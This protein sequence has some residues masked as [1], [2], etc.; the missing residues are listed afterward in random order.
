[1]AGILKFSNLQIGQ[2]SNC[3]WALPAARAIRSY[4]CR[5]F[6]QAGIH[7]YH[8]YVCK[9]ILLYSKVKESESRSYRK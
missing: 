4:A 9:V 2:S 5:P 6:A 3:F 8:S 7:F 1:M